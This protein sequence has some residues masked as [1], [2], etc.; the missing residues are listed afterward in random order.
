MPD[1]LSR[2]TFAA[3]L[4]TTFVLHLDASQRV[5]IELIDVRAGRSSPRQ[6]QF[7]LLFR[8]PLDCPFGQGAWTL[9]HAALGEIEI[10]L[11]PVDRDAAGYYYEAVFNRLL[12]AAG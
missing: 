8:G 11:S 3:H 9:Q 4:H 1:S 6:E 12:P 10:F 2:A 7:S 5:A